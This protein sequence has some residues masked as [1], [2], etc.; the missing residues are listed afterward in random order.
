MLQ[1]SSVYPLF[2]PIASRFDML[3]RQLFELLP[4][5]AMTS[6]KYVRFSD[7][8]KKYHQGR[9]LRVQS[10]GLGQQFKSHPFHFGTTVLTV[11]RTPVK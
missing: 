1:Y 5:L 9:A 8:L 2:L 6:L 10:N 11:P 4:I 3:T 7:V